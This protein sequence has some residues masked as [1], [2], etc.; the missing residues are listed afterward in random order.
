MPAFRKPDENTD[1]LSLQI[2]RDAAFHTTLQWLRLDKQGR[3]VETKV[4]PTLAQ[5]AAVCS[6]RVTSLPGVDLRKKKEQW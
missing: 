2:D 1:Q 3:C 4:T 6:V 5:V